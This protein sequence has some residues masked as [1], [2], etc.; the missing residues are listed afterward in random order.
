[1]PYL[2]S[3]FMCVRPVPVLV[4]N[5]RSKDY[6]QF[7][8]WCDSNNLNGETYDKIEDCPPMVMTVDFEPFYQMDMD[9]EHKDILACFPTLI[10]DFYEYIYG[11]FSA[12]TLRDSIFPEPLFKRDVANSIKFIQEQDRF[13]DVFFPLGFQPGNGFEWL[14]TGRYRK[15]HFS[16]FGELTTR[17]YIEAAYNHEYDN[18]VFHPELVWNK[19]AADFKIPYSKGVSI[20]GLIPP[21]TSTVCT[22]NFP[23]DLTKR[24]YDIEA[25]AF[26]NQFEETKGMIDAYDHPRCCLQ[27]EYI[28]VAKYCPCA[29]LQSGLHSISITILAAG[30]MYCVFDWKMDK[31]TIRPMSLEDVS[32][33]RTWNASPGYPYNRAK[34]NT[35][36][37]AYDRFYALIKHVFTMSQ[38]D[39][40]PTI[41]N[42]FP[43]DEILRTSKVYANDVRT[44]IAPSICH[45]LVGQHCTMAISNRVGKQ[46]QDS[47]TQIGRTRFRGDVDR[48]ARRVMRFEFIEEYDISKWD[49]SIK[50]GLLKIFWFYC[51]YVLDSDLLTHFWQLGNVFESTIYSHLLHR[52]GEMLRKA[53]GVPSG[54]TL[55]SYANSWIHTYLNFVM[56]CDLLPKEGPMTIDQY[57]KHFKLHCDFV[58]YGDDGLMGYSG[59][60]APWFNVTTKSQ[61]LKEKFDM[62]L[63]PSNCKVVNKLYFELV[64]NDADGISFLG[65]ILRPMEDGTIQPVFKMTKVVNSFILNAGRKTYSPAEQI[66]I[67]ICHYVECFFHP[68]AP[69]LAKWLTLVLDKFKQSHVQTKFIDSEILDYLG[70]NANS[71]ILNVRELIANGALEKWVYETFYVVQIPDG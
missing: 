62:T 65:D 43:K 3:F 33:E 28:S 22:T 67:A 58:C 32:K 21:K 18:S 52:S 38:F 36:R 56:Y 48:T 15:E 7:K 23:K 13:E 57:I 42:V 53:Y 8:I 50:A 17:D 70:V 34:C 61:W 2:Q 25:K 40:M 19:K 68:H 14:N 30:F 31:T 63:D 60:I 37:Q 47:H 44:I 9:Q 69:I 6:I 27:N 59:D 49:R 41:Y 71:L 55:T 51:W 46:F 24:A 11:I 54:F 20:I 45:Q 26:F 64:N 39:W 66:L 5:P 16:L 12:T 35:A 4:A 10:N 1:M 29:M